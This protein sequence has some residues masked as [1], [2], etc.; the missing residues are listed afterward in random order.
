MK[1]VYSLLTA[2][3][4]AA[5]VFA[6]APQKMTYQAVIRNTGN[7]LV[8]NT[9]VGMRISILQGSVTGSS[10]YTELQF[11]SSNTNG[12]VTFEIGGGAVVSGSFSSINWANGPY[13]IKTETDPLGGT[14]YSI[15]GTSQL[16][17]VPY[18]LHAATAGNIPTNVSSFT[19]DSGYLTAEVDGSVTNEIQTLSLSG[20]SLSISGGNSVTL[21]AEVDGSVTN[22]IQTLS[23]SGSSLSISGGNSVT[24]PASG[25]GGTLDA[26]YDFGGSGLGRFITADAGEV[27]ITTNSPSGIA[28][29]AENTNTGVAII[30]NVTNASNTFSA[31]QAST[32]SS[33]ATTS[34]IIGNSSGA[35]WGISG[36]VQSSA[37]AQAAVYGSNLRT[38]GG[39][40]VMGIGFNGA[41]G[42]TNYS[43]GYGVYAENF[44]AIAPL[45][46]GV[47]VGGRGYYGVFGEDRY[48]GSIAGAYGV[49]SNGNFGATGTKT[50]NIDHPKDPENKFLRHFSMESDEVLN[51]YRGT[52]VFDA[53]GEATVTLPGYFSDINRNVS[54]Q[55]TPVGA[56]MPLFVK[57]KVDGA[58]KFVIGGGI[59]GKEVSWAVY[60]ERND[61]YMQKHP[62]QRSTEVE[63]RDGQKGKYLIPSLYGA[64]EDKAMFGNKPA[65]VGQSEMKI[66]E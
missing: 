45:G 60:A 44:D 50:F 19:N 7:A 21:P 10:V 24:L 16:L 29:R 14:A 2:V 43:S 26:A 46:N 40:G 12:L 38:T 59:A 25:G 37:T 49:Y 8:T 61:L 36:Q 33:S 52:I 34:A 63:K 65:A 5:A 28:L 31:I 53:N 20:S 42:Q 30:S 66:Q 35:A 3:F 18:A 47:G 6:Q 4:M 15:T 57:E 32:N 51:V 27:S 58:N 39:H 9:T 54:Y 64:G 22:E 56:Y 13:F 1:K 48:S 55:L 23:L 41:V 11:P 62:E 17:S